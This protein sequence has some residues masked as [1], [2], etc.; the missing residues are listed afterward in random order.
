MYKTRTEKN[1]VFSQVFPFFSSHSIHFNFASIYSTMFSIQSA[2][3]KKRTHKTPI[4][5][6]M[7]IPKFILGKLFAGSVWR[8]CADMRLPLLY[9][10]LQELFQFYFLPLMCYSN[11]GSF[12]SSHNHK[13]NGHLHHPRQ[14]CA[15]EGFQSNCNGKIL[16]K[17]FE[18]ESRRK[19]RKS[20][21]DFILK[22][23][24][25]SSVFLFL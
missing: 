21:E 13:A 24:C 16:K 14:T 25:V 11:I 19:V 17:Y 12:F 6:I 15:G 1:K 3:K 23:C 20:V 10:A 4:H 5:K 2:D 9:T 18:S 7:P 22:I 8:F